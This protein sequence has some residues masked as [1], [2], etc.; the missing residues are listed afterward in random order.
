[1]ENDRVAAL[2]HNY[3]MTAVA[4]VDRAGHCNGLD[5]RFSMS[6]STRLSIMKNDVLAAVGPLFGRRRGIESIISEVERS[7]RT[8]AGGCVHEMASVSLWPFIEC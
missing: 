4:V 2:L 5:S 8:R 3:Q 1:V 7:R 6:V